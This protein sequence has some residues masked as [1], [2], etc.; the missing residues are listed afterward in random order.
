MKINILK[1]IAFGVVIGSLFVSC[2]KEEE[3]PT[4]TT[5]TNTYTI[6]TTYSFIDASSKSTVDFGGQ[7]TRLVMLEQMGA[8]MGGTNPVSE[9][10]LLNMFD[11]TGFTADSLNTSGKRLSDKTAASIDYFTAN[12]GEKNDVIEAFKK[13]LK[14]AELTTNANVEASVGLPGYYMDG[15]KKRYFSANGLEPQQVFLKGMMGAC[16]LDQTLNTYLSLTKL[17]GGLTKQNNT[18]RILTPEKNYTDMEHFWDEAY[19]YIFGVDNVNVTPAVYKYWSSYINQVDVDPD[20]SNVKENILNAFIKGRAAITNKDYTTRDAQIAII[21]KEL[22]K[23]VAVR[24]VYYMN[25]GK[26]K[27]A[28]NNGKGAFH[29][30]SEGYGF[31]WSLRFTQNPDTKLPYFSKD[32]VKSL[33]DRLMGGT[34]GLYAVDYLNTELDKIAQDIATR[35][36]FTVAQAIDATK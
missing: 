31:I 9:S 20:F 34:N 21:K 22:S 12:L 23:V 25:E 35:F 19:G 16:L 17:D 8:L 13:Q 3:K 11:G 29:A 28:T 7:K 26:S 1:N 27:L 10:T 14:E 24:A 15:S 33:L 30:L 5:S 2:K 6:P 18:N 36:G 4:V 32:E